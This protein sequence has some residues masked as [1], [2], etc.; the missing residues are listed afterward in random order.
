MK[1]TC[2]KLAGEG[3]RGQNRNINLM[4]S[5][6]RL[7]RGYRRYVMITKPRCARLL[8]FSILTH[9]ICFMTS[10]VPDMAGR[11]KT[12]PLVPQ[13]T[14][15]SSHQSQKRKSESFPLPQIKEGSFCQLGSAKN[16][17]YEIIYNFN[18]QDSIPMI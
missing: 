1:I 13:N 5:G 18:I 2:A 10:K 12:R 7:Q 16:G 11:E 4:F 9:T 15:P 14:F 6:P 3:H 17:T 8:I